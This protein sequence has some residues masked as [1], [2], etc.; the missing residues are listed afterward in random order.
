M[1]EIS[2]IEITIMS[3]PDDGSVLRFE[4]PKQGDVYTIGRREECD[5]VLPFDS[6][7]SRSHAQL[8]F[9]DGKWFIR[10][11]GSRNG[12]FVGKHKIEAVTQLEFDQMF[13]VGRTWLKLSGYS[14]YP[15]KQ[16]LAN[17]SKE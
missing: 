2:P 15:A 7:I 6:Q 4:A 3:G 5:V 8:F 10:D 11:L 9:S 16:Y 1:P 17:Q 14:S 13:R 12:T